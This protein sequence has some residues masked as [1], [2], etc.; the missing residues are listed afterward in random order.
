MNAPKS[1]RRYRTDGA[2]GG[3]RR[4]R[5]GRGSDWHVRGKGQS[6]TSEARSGTPWPALPEDRSS[7]QT[8][9]TKE[10]TDKRDQ[11]VVEI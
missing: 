1:I 10:P 9:R 7:N 5:P 6:R 3:G 4:E 11:L 8:R 2:R